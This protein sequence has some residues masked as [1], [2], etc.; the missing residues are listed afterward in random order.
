M[1]F[2]SIEFSR[3]VNAV[4]LL[5]CFVFGSNYIALLDVIQ[6]TAFEQWV[7]ITEYESSIG[8]C[9][10]LFVLVFI[11]YLPNVKIAYRILA[12]LYCM[13]NLDLS[14]A[15]FYVTLFQPDAANSAFLSRFGYSMAA[16]YCVFPP[17]NFTIFYNLSY[18]IS[19]THATAYL[20]GTAFS[21]FVASGMAL[22]TDA[23]YVRFFFVVANAVGCILCTVAVFYFTPTV[24]RKLRDQKVIT[25]PDMEGTTPRPVL[26]AMWRMFRTI[27]RQT[28]SSLAVIFLLFLVSYCL[29][30]RFFFFDD[31]IHAVPPPYAAYDHLVAFTFA[32]GDL[33]GRALQ[34]LPFIPP[35]RA[36]FIAG[37]ALTALA[38]VTTLTLYIVVPLCRLE[39]AFGI[40]NPILAG[41]FGVLRGY[42]V[43][44]AYEQAIVDV[45][46]R[47][48][49]TLVSLSRFL[50]WL[51]ADILKTVLLVVF[52]LIF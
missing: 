5:C 35:R 31:V 41:V 47:L 45:E 16:L 22:A 37:V 1:P 26:A 50:G 17:L 10:A 34:F 44:C 27:V 9:L 18:S 23:L 20:V 24:Y 6:H 15:S 36:V 3:S 21:R 19:A 43:N 42:I 51:F 2:G 13:V 46:P 48:G 30:P 32:S 14:V 11:S 29:A 12:V 49:I 38:F 4:T 33:L 39:D 7:M 25:L 8:G 40:V 52:A 28:A